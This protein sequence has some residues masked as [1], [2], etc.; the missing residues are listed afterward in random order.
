MENKEGWSEGDSQF[1]VM[2]RGEKKELGQVTWIISGCG[3][4]REKQRPRER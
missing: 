2:D 1:K 4:L 3:L